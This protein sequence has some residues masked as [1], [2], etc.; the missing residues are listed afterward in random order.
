MT[1]PIVVQL[2]TIAVAMATLVIIVTG[3]VLSPLQAQQYVIS[4]YAGGAPPRTPARGVDVSIGFASGIATDGARNVYFASSDLNCVF[5]LD[6]GGVLT[7]VAGNSRP[8]YS[9]DGGL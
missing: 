1:R 8:G 5:K 9:G 4:T 3:A 7:R 6:P 2:R